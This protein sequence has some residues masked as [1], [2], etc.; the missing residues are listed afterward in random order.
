MSK[1]LLTREE[2]IRVMT[3]RGLPEVCAVYDDDTIATLEAQL[4]KL[5]KE[6][7][8]FRNSDKLCISDWKARSKSN[9]IL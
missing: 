4:A 2:Y 1:L 6:G 7:V 5:E 9:E 3:N 8:Y